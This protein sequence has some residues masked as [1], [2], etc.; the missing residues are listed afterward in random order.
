MDGF[1]TVRIPA[2]A[3]VRL[4]ARELLAIERAAGQDR[5]LGDVSA[6]AAPDETLEEAVEVPGMV[7]GWDV[8]VPARLSAAEKEA[9][10][11]WAATRGV[12]PKYVTRQR[13]RDYV[14][15]TGDTALEHLLEEAA[16]RRDADR[17]VPHALGALNEEGGAA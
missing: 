13:I 4:S 17:L 15:A 5:S 9:L 3:V 6:P 14:A 11:D 12:R 1:V 16:P 10:K 8:P 7:P 2:G